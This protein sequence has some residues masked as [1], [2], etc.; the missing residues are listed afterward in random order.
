MCVTARVSYP[1]Q[2]RIYD[3]RPV[4]WVS[5]Q[6]LRQTGEG[7]GSRRI[8]S[9]LT[10]R[11]LR[12]YL[13]RVFVEG[14]GADVLLVRPDRGFPLRLHPLEVGDVPQL[15]ED[16]EV[17]QRGAVV[18]AHFAVGEGDLELV[19]ICGATDSTRGFMAYLN[20]SIFKG[21]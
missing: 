2:G 11:L 6:C 3:L 17:Q 20:G 13:L 4:S 14:I 16:T 5:P 12:A 7:R 18:N 8:G 19:S 21:C 9:G 15:G 10:T 1:V